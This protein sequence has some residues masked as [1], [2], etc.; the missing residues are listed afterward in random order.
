MSKFSKPTQ[1]KF[2]RIAPTSNATKTEI[3][4]PTAP[5]EVKSPFDGLTYNV[6]F[7]N[8]MND[9]KPIW[10]ILNITEEEYNRQ[11]NQ[12]KPVEEQ[13]EEPTPT[14]TDDEPPAVADATAPPAPE[15]PL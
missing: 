3:L 2:G 10:E 14:P 8:A 4:E 13:K 12:P 1:S 5:E 7:N 6:N 15:E 11:Y 9:A